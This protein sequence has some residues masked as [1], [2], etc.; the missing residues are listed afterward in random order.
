VGI[1]LNRSKK[2]K[3]T[4]WYSGDQKP[5]RVGAYQRK[6][7]AKGGWFSWFSWWDGKRFSHSMI[8]LSDCQNNG[9]K[10]GYSDR[11]DLP[12]RGVTK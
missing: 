5:V 11:Q 9:M 8:L 12:W 2:M 6:Y 1:D 4:G 3:E 10:Y 7:F